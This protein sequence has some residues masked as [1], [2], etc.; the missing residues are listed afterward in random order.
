L[1]LIAIFVFF[2]AVAEAKQVAVRER[3]GS[4]RVRDG[5][6]RAF[7]ALPA[8]LSLREAAEF[9][10]D[11]LQSDYPVVSDGALVG[12]LQHDDM[13]RA[14]DGGFEGT[15]ADVMHRDVRPVEETDGLVSVIETAAPASGETLPVT[16]S[17]HLTRLLDP[18]RVF[19]LVKAR[20]ALRQSGRTIPT[21]AVRRPTPE[22]T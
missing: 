18:R 3:F 22:L 13:V 4:Y 11:G 15:V 2:G 21:V 7:R 17:G 9:T 14:L 1:L 6:I 10:L 16:A 5:M 12:M 8:N 20:A 19:E